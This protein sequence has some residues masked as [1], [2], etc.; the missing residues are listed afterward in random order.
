MAASPA[1][2]AS[3]PRP[4]SQVGSPAPGGSGQPA[5]PLRTPPPTSPPPRAQPASARAERGSCACWQAGCRHAAGRGVRRVGLN[6]PLPERDRRP[7]PSGRRAPPLSPEGGWII[8]RRRPISPSRLGRQGGRTRCMPRR[9]R[10]LSR[11]AP[12]NRWN[13]PRRRKC[14]ASSIALARARGRISK[15]SARSRRASTTASRSHG[16][17]SRRR[18]L[19][20]SSWR[21]RALR[22]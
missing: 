20:A 2:S 17:G 14:R 5:V 16:Y 11:P 3:P 8:S 6:P 13:R 21:W 7:R 4:P 1:P 10:R 18:S 9:R 12:T 19:L 22:S 15:A